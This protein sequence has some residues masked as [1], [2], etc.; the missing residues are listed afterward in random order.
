MDAFKV[1]M[2]TQRERLH[3]GLERAVG[4]RKTSFSTIQS[5]GDCG[6]GGLDGI[7]GMV[8]VIICLWLS[9]LC[10]SAMMDLHYFTEHRYL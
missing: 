6:Q 9:E 8:L 4:I 3:D 1:G 5:R 2:E 7:I 10:L